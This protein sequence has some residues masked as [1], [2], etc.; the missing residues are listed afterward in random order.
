MGS[1]DLN[2]LGISGKI[3]PIV[4]Y[5][6]KYGKQVYRE[7]FVPNDPK[8]PKQLAYR[9]KFSLANSG[10][11]PF[12]K[13]IKEGHNQ[14]DNA[15]RSVISLVLREAILGE[16]PN[17]SIDYS[18]IPLSDGKLKLPEDITASIQNNSL[19]ISWNP[20]ITGLPTRNRSDNKMNIVCFDESLQKV[21]AMYNVARRGD[22]VV[23]IDINEILEQ[24]D[25]SQT[26][27]KDDLRFWIYF[28]SMDGKDNSG[29][30]YV[31]V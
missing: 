14:N 2:K 13:F 24:E 12:L 7:Y 29:S 25:S 15:Y 31:E 16:Y 1:I 5:K 8:T 3:G 19:Q 21:F 10:L 4:A 20:E 18:K 26:I 27:N 11:S 17:F 23:N 9:M 22:G 6:T 30:W 28:S